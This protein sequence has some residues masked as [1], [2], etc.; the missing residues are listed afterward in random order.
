[1]TEVDGKYY[2]S[3][4]ETDDIYTEL[5]EAIWEATPEEMEAAFAAAEEYVKTLSIT[6]SEVFTVAPMTQADMDALVGKTLGELREAGYEERESG[7]EGD[8]IAYV[9]TA[10]SCIWGIRE[11]SPY[12]SIHQ[13]YL[14]ST[15]I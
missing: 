3:V 10:R 4:A 7:T 9:I 2:R 15:I 6:Y 1:M 8:D 12:S 11:P 5:Q 13:T 14:L